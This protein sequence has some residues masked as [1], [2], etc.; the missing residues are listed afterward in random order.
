VQKYNL[1]FVPKASTVT[2]PLATMNR[3]V[4]EDQGESEGRRGEGILVGCRL[5]R[6]GENEF[7]MASQPSSAAGFVDLFDIWHCRES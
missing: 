1:R 7:G 4:L 2:S 3:E 5:D 6:S